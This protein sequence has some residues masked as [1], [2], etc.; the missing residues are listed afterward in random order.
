MNS[1]ANSSS[2]PPLSQVAAIL[3]ALVFPSL[4]TLTYF[5][6]FSQRSPGFQQGTYALGKSIQFAFPLLW[7]LLVLKERL[8]Q[9]RMTTSGIL[10]GF[11]FGAVVSVIMLLLYHLVL[12]PS[13]FFADATPAIQEK[14]SGLGLD[15]AW[16]FVALGIFYA[17]IHSV[18]EEYYWRWFVFGQL[19]RCTPLGVAILFS[20]LGFMAHHV[21]LLASYFGWTSPVTY[22]FSCGVAIG[23]VVWTCL[24]EYSGSLLGP[25]LSHALIDAAIFTVGYDLA[26]F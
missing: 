11:L 14:I 22:V 7:V 10:P 25:W 9:K 23:G 2:P 15:S 1:E 8:G 18:L 24:Y 26:P 16:Q 3:A 5:V 4:L 19:R 20:S 13:G 12:R 21:I 17:A 6:V